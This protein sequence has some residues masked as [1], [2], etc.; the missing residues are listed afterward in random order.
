MDCRERI[1]SEDYY[2]IITDFPLREELAED[3][4]CYIPVE[5]LYNLIY[6]NKKRV[7]SENEY[8][9]THRILP[10]LYGLMQEGGSG[11]PGAGFDP[12][13]L[14]VSG[15]TQ[16]QRE[17]LNL[18]GRG[19]VLVVIDTGIDYTSPVFLNPD[20]SSRILA[21]WDQTIQTGNPPDSLFYGT[22]YTRE[23]INRALAAPNPYEVVK[24]RDEIGHGTSMAAVAAGSR[25]ENGLTYLGAAP[26][27]DIVVVKLKPCKRYLRDFYLL[28]EEVPA[29][30]ETDIMLGILYGNRFADT[31]RRPVVFCLGIGTSYGDH[32]GNSALSRYLDSVAVQ[33]SRAVVVAGGNEGN[34]DHHFQ[35]NLNS[36][37]NSDIGSSAEGG[38][39]TKLTQR[40]ELRVGANAKG[41]LL[42]FWGTVPDVFSIS[43][44]SPGGETIPAIRLGIQD[45]ITYG[46]I[47]ER[48]KITIAGELVEPGSG[49]ELIK[50]R[51]VNPTPGIW[52]F[53]V[54]SYGE[55]YNGNFHIWLP[56]TEFLNA[57]AYFLTPSPYITL[58][59][60][61][62]SSSVISV[63]TYNGNNN[64]F[65]INSGR[66]YSRTGD[67]SPDFAAPGV[68]ISTPG[69][70]R[71][72]SSMAAAITAGAVAQFMQWAVV[73]QN[74]VVVESREIK[75]YFARG[76]SRSFDVTY[77][78]REWGYGR[79]NMVGTFDALI[80]V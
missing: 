4:L 68:N 58:T 38:G 76:A 50:M 65:Y 10:K 43:I 14:I 32:A 36:L 73:E 1:L 41:F 70:S 30:E 79:L 34:A 74:N 53:D 29:Y 8:F 21:I 61:G 63:S 11:L 42:H 75:N 56:I 6:F 78:N 60:P 7:E 39:T 46:F 69:G 23:E 27:A 18:T 67:I 64:S 77:P 52:S 62:M 13:N 66:G 51:I 28:P 71:T 57:E 26:E 48:T 3:D 12:N 16:I 19:C 33:R 72:G 2:D 31:F 17:P 9:Y 45:A 25:L 54:V 35:G 40:V 22:E 24:S 49:E 5:N 44:R 47:Y 20:G 55:I 80:G 37:R 59:E 15:I